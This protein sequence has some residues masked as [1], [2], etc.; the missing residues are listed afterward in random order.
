MHVELACKPQYTIHMSD[1][2][3]YKTTKPRSQD[4]QSHML[5]I[6]TLMLA[7][8]KNTSDDHTQTS[9]N[10]IYNFMTHPTQIHMSTPQKIEHTFILRN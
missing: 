6:P 5:K 7:H 4:K 1:P 10:I 8:T 3:A 2:P 9:C